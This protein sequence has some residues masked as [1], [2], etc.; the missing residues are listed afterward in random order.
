MADINIKRGDTFYYSAVWE[1]ATLSDLRSQVRNN[2]GQL[3][4]D[5]EI[6]ATDNPNTFL[7]VV[8]DTT[9]WPVGILYTDVEF[10]NPRPISSKTL[11]IKVERDV[12]QP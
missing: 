5:V 4:S 6:S 1:G 2:L 10:S 3:V 12:T 8:E 9:K 7:F 11:E